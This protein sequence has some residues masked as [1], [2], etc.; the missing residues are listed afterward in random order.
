MPARWWVCS[1]QVRTAS[2]MSKGISAGVVRHSHR[3]TSPLDAAQSQTAS[4][5]KPLRY[6]PKGRVPRGIVWDKPCSPLICSASRNEVHVDDRKALGIVAALEFK[7]LVLS[8]VD[9]HHL[10]WV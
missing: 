10:P 4:K 9:T 2:T 1:V 6:W 3:D 5:K 8:G 7:R